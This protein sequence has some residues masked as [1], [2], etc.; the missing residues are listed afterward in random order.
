MKKSQ[1]FFILTMFALQLFPAPK[2]EAWLQRVGCPCVDMGGYGYR[3]AWDDRYAWNEEQESLAT[4]QDCHNLP[5][6]EP[7]SRKNG[8]N[9]GSSSRGCSSCNR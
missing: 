3:D 8:C 5:P 4:E 1:L 9:W 2:L 7:F 6:P